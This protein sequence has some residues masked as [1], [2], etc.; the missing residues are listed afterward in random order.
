VLYFLLSGREPPEAYELSQGAVLEYPAGVS[1]RVRTA[2]AAAMQPHR[3]QR[4]Q[5]TGAFLAALDGQSGTGQAHPVRPAASPVQRIPA[6]RCGGEALGLDAEDW[7]W[8]EGGRFLMGSPEDEEGREDC[9]RQHWVEVGGFAL[10]KTPVTWAMYARY[11]RAV[12]RDLPEPPEWAGD[13]HPVVHV[14][15][16]DAVRYADWVSAQSGWRCRLPTEAEWEYACRAGTQTAYWWGPRIGHANANC[17]GCG[18]RWNGKATS[19]VGSFPANPWGLYDMHGNVIEWTGSVYDFD[20]G[21]AELEH[22][23]KNSAGS[24][25][26]RGGSWYSKPRWVRSA[27]RTWYTPDGRC[28][29][30]G[31]RLA[32]DSL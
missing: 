28:D 9:E 30:L 8:L 23:G 6:P 10:M 3:A 5:S 26:S 17:L 27:F 29:A 1:E 18:G 13:D 12:D 22:V 24:R 7:V 15:W 16:D 19:P 21:G 32:Q 20:Y 14:D 31:F 4:P 25:V 11:C 2:I